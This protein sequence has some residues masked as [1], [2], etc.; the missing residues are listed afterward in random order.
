[1]RASINALTAALIVG[2]IVGLALTPDGR[3]W[4]RNPTLMLGSANASAGVSAGP[5]APQVVAT[6][7]RPEPALPAAPRVTPLSQRLAGGELVVGVIG[8]SM[9]DGLWT[10]V[11]RDLRH[12]DGVRVVR[13][14]EVS[15]GLSRYDYVNVQDKTA[16]QLREQPIDA[17]VV[18]FGTNDAQAIEHDGVIH[19][20]GTPGWREIYARRVDDLVALLRANDVAVYWVGL[21]RMKRESFDGRMSLINELVAERMAALDVPYIDTVALTSNEGGA[22]DAYLTATDG[23]RR[24]MRAHDGIHMSMAGYLR[25][26][27]PVTE[28][29]RADAGLTRTP[30]GAGG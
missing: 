3:G 14:A 21:P 5:P 2:V 12:V 25:L 23:R 20:F 1:M 17:A 10:G 27:E 26:T 30:D 9:A 16:R 8:D 7:A 18:M 13:M 15:T 6:V 29:L 11:Y 28:R 22:Y 24:L 4:L 19:P